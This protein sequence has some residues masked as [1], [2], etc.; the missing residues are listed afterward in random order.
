[1]DGGTCESTAYCQLGYEATGICVALGNY[2]NMNIRTG[3]IGPEYI[4]VSD[5]ADLVK[6][7]V[8]LTTTR[9]PYT[10][11]DAALQGRLKKIEKE[12]AALLRRTRPARKR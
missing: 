8:A 5:F 10:G 6:W 3:R 11:T 2:H 12:Y 9:R 4:S 7:F 1:M